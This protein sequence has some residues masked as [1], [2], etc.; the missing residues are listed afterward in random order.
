MAYDIRETTDRVDIRGS[1][2]SD[3]ETMELSDTAVTGNLG[4]ATAV[5]NQGGT[6]ALEDWKTGADVTED[7]G[8]ARGKEELAVTIGVERQS[9]VGGL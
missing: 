9:A 6:R 2:G 7:R 3:G 5:S 1:Q 4:G 8:G